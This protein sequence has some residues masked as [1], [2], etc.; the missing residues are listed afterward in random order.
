VPAHA[1]FFDF[2]NA[3]SEGMN[4]QA[5][6]ELTENNLTST[7]GVRAYASQRPPF[8]AISRDIRTQTLKV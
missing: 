3:Q 5:L 7:Q 4:E 8:V 2:G 6:I 1:V